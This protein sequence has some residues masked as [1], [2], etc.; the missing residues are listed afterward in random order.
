[1]GEGTTAAQNQ[2]LQLRTEEIVDKIS[3]LRG[4]ESRGE[5]AQRHDPAPQRKLGDPGQMR[6]SL[7]DKP[8]SFAEG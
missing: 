3:L 6:D 1:M 7:R 8:D 5:S 4:L 2:N